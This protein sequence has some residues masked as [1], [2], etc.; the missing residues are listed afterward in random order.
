MSY[1]YI[2]VGAGITGITAA[3]EVANIL[4]KTVLLID[5]RNHIGGNCF[6]YVNE[7]GTLVHRYGPH[8]FHTN[9]PQVYNYL[10][11]FTTWNVYNHKV[12]YKIGNELIPIPFNL[13]SIDKCL[14]NNSEKVKDALLEEYEV[15]SKVSVKELIDSDN[16]SLRLLG[17]YIY[18][19][20]YQKEIKKIYGV[21]D[22]NQ[23]M[24]FIDKMPPVIVSYDCRYYNDVY[25]TIPASGYTKMF[26]NMLTNH[27]INV[28]L[29]KDYKDIL[30]IDYENKKVYYEGEEFNG[31][32]IFT[33]KID[34]FFNY[35][36]GELPYRSSVLLNEDIQEI[37]FQE[38]ATINYPDDYHFTRITEFKYITGQQ[39]FY[40]TLQFEFPVEYKKDN[41]E[42][43]NPFYAMDTL[44]NK[45]LYERYEKLSKEFE[46]VTFIGRLAEYK[47]MN[48]DESVE[49]VL[50]LINYKLMGE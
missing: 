22:T 37:M 31:Q 25:Q 7:Y 38:N 48:M 3:E 35:K 45:K 43:N 1:D 16:E 29:E 11:L 2:I 23:I 47:D 12:V 18:T 39:N 9:N 33:G 24:N 21:E 15:N 36:Y 17:N 40:T 6:D 42:Q 50:D 49:K 30:K 19:N 27:N 44:E 5:K 46:N 41:P 10:S 32:I 26:E 8:I 20:I 34:E 28:L 13:I 4:E 14:P